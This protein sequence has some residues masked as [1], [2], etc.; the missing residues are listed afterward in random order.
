SP[1]GNWI[2][3]PSLKAERSLNQTLSLRGKNDKGLLDFSL[4]QT[5]YRNFLFEEEKTYQ[6]PNEYYNEHSCYYNPKYCN[7]TLTEIGQQMVNIDKARVS[8]VEFRGEL[9][10]DQVMSVPEVL[11]V[12]GAWCYSKGKVSGELGSLLFIPPLKLVLGFD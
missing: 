11:K 10:L 4:Y 2:A 7:P 1:Y 9:N 8:G 3:N 12:S 6:V 5:R